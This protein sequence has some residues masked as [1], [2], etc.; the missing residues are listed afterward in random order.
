MSKLYVDEISPKT[1]G[2]H[3]V[4]TNRPFFYATVDQTSTQNAGGTIIPFGTVI[5]DTENAY[6]AG[7]YNYTVPIAGLWL[8][9][10]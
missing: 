6:N 4:L 8:L 7:T 9:K 2:S 1:T 5:E 10:M 3:V